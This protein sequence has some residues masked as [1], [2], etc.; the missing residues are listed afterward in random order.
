MKKQKILLG[1]GCLAAFSLFTLAVGRVD[2]RPM[3]PLGSAVGFGTLNGWFHRLTGV[4]LALYALTDWLSL[5]PLGLAAGFGVL[6]LCQ[7]IGRK[8]L[9]LVDRSLLALGSF[10]LAVGAAFVLFELF[11]VNYRPIL[12]DGVLEAS[13]PSSTT[14][15][16]LTVLPTAAMDLRDRIRDRNIRRPVLWAMALLTVFMMAARLVS[17][18]HWLTDILGGIL[19]SAGLVTLY[20]AFRK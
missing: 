5:V 1:L 14:L 18:V 4:H 10:Y 12:I 2:V 17:G 7:W 16:V 13:Y 8:K 9:R 6:G 20:S 15:L 3:G 11:P 19:L